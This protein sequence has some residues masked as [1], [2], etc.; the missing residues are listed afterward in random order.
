[1]TSVTVLGGA[2][3]Q[4]RQAASLLHARSDVAEV[5]VGDLNQDAAHQAADRIGPKC[6][7]VAIDA[8]DGD[9]IASALAAS[10]SDVLL[11]CA[12]PFRRIGTTPLNAAI[13]AGVHY[14]DLLDDAHMV[15]D[16]FRCSDAAERAGITA[17]IGF[18]FS[19]GLTNILGKL[20]VRD[21]SDVEELHWSYLCNA[22]LAVEP[23][24]M[25]HRVQLFG[26]CA[27]MIV[28]GQVRAVQGGSEA[29]EVDWPG[30]G[31][32]T[33]S[34]IAHPEPVMAHRYFPNLR[35]AVVRASYTSDS[36]AQMLATLGELGFDSEQPLDGAVGGVSPEEFIGHFLT[37]AAFQESRVWRDVVDAEE[38]IGPVDAARVVAK[39]QRGGEETA[40]GYLFVGRRR[41]QSTYTVAA[42]AA[43]LVGT[44]ELRRPGVHAPEGFE[45]ERLVE[46]CQKSG[47]GIEE[48]D[49]RDVPEF[50]SRSVSS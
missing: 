36:F 13:R 41:W 29:I 26:R 31:T 19:P 7:G 45:A 9:A 24:L 42:I 49:A 5:V 44:G 22:T 27:A 6:R 30:F 16:L 37:S 34:V 1:M 40:R 15:P 23:H 21:M 17:A 14:V 3:L 48:I 12:G 8:M 33:A 39:G 25:A 10:S 50:A 35:R 20:A 18:G 47:L 4:G 38:R 11:N 2:G 32:L 43:Y 46:E 28:D